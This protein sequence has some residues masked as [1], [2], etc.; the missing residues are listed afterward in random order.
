MMGAMQV[1][2]RIPFDENPEYLTYARIAYVAAQVIVLL[3]NYYISMKVSH[4]AMYIS[5]LLSSIRPADLTFAFSSATL[6]HTGQESKRPDCA[7]I[8]LTQVANVTRT[9]RAD[10]DDT[11]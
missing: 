5:E 10:H 3:I 11:S 4:L 8:C 9:W 7:E 6:P 2:K 1:A